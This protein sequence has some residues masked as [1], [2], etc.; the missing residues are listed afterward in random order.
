MF[1]KEKKSEVCEVE[2][3][4]Q[5][6]LT[7]VLPNLTFRLVVLVSCCLCKLLCNPTPAFTLNDVHSFSIRDLQCKRGK[8]SVVWMPEK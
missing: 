7:P 5:L 2:P 6:I 3:I 1:Y 8:K 4:Q